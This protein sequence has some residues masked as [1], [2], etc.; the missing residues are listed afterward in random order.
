MGCEY[1][2][3]GGAVGE[4]LGDPATTLGYAAIEHGLLG[5]LKN[6]GKPNMMEPEKHSRVLHE[7]RNQHAWHRDPKDIKLPRSHGT[8]LGDHLAH[9]D[10]D[11]SADHMHGHA[12]VGS[13]GK[14]HLKPI[15][16]KMAGSILANEPHPEGLRGAIEYLANAQKGEDKLERYMKSLFGSGKIDKIESNNSQSLK[17]YI[18]ELQ[19]NPSELLNMGGNLGHYLPDHAAQVSSSIAQALTYLESIKPKPMQGAPLDK[20]T[21]ISPAEQAQ[22]DRQLKIA[23]QPLLALE[24]L[25]KG[26]LI[27]DDLTTVQTIYPGL[28]QSMITKATEQLIDTMAKE[29]AMPY[30]QRIGLGMLLG[31]PLDSSMTPESMQA[32]MKSAAPQQAD[33]QQGKSSEAQLKQVDK[34]AKIIGTEEQDREI[35]GE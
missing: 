7:A 4:T 24:H 3:E 27:P 35:E 30:H 26:T 15:M 11:K 28:H 10:H 31:Q 9:A 14:T 22:F 8:K 5:L 13:T 16:Q 23:Q 25:Q 19:E 32:I 17:E 18:E 2:A 12:L 34:M 33:Q 1:F 6:V 29:E 20:V 21:S